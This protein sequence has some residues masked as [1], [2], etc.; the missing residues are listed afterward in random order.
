MAC[1]EISLP[2]TSTSSR[3]MMPWMHLMRCLRRG[4]MSWKSSTWVR[5]IRKFNQRYGSWWRR[6]SI[7]F[8]LCRQSLMWV[9]YWMFAFFLIFPFFLLSK[10]PPSFAL[11]L[12][13]I[14]KMCFE[15]YIFSC[16]TY[17]K[18]AH[19][20][21]NVYKFQISQKSR[22]SLHHSNPLSAEMLILCIRN[23]RNKQISIA[24]F[25]SALARARFYCHSN[26][27]MHRAK[28]ARARAVEGEIFK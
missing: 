16:F 24:S 21:S 2:F 6:K 5:Q 23:L 10:I 17:R 8:T 27:S 18:L 26:K 4:G 7:T 20:L 28:R 13:S 3:R 15:M 14:C 9:W 22:K 19:M 25:C 12:Y 1:R 11:D